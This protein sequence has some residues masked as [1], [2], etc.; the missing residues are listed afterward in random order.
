LLLLP[1]PATHLIAADGHVGL[2]WRIQGIT[3]LRLEVWA[4]ALEGVCKA[5]LQALLAAIPAGD[6]LHA[7]NEAVGQ[8]LIAVDIHQHVH[9]C[10]D[11]YRTRVCIG[12][13]SWCR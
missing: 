11:T 8:L 1:V 12:A 7:G 4:G 10:R 9:T 5:A 3:K 2:P 6:A 13:N